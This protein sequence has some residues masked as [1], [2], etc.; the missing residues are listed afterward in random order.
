MIRAG[1]KKLKDRRTISVFQHLVSGNSIATQS[2][3]QPTSVGLSQT[4]PRTRQ[5]F[6]Q[7]VHPNRAPSTNQGASGGGGLLD[8]S[9]GKLTDAAII[10]IRRRR[11]LQ[12]GR[13]VGVRV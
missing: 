3:V 8:P 1:R 9:V 7:P 6:P 10:R 11:G 5:H 2:L 13:W 4:S 12:C